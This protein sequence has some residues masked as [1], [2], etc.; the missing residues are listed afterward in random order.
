[1]RLRYNKNSHIKNVCSKKAKHDPEARQWV[2]RSWD[3][4]EQFC[5]S[6]TFR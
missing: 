3:F 2:Q 6:L 4:A 1:M 5:K